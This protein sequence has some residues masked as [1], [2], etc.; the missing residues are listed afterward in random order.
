MAKY[1]EFQPHVFWDEYGE[2]TI[3]KYRKAGWLEP[4]RYYKAYKSGEF[5]GRWIRITSGQLEEF[6]EQGR[7]LYGYLD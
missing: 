2:F 6:K 3:K 7:F 4:T 1:G 5:K